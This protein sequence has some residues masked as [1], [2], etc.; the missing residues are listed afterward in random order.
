MNMKSPDYL[1]GYVDYWTG[2][3]PSSSKPD[4]M[5]GWRAGREAKRILDELNFSTDNSDYQELKAVA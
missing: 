5:T 3:V 1:R 2:L 4:Y